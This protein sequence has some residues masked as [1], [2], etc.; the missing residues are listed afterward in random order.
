MVWL[1]QLPSTSFRRMEA[2]V[3]GAL[4]VMTEKYALV[5]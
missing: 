4:L 5:T 1:L 3:V 2:A